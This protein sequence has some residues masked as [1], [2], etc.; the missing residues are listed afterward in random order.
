MK[1]LLITIATFLTSSMLGQSVNNMDLKS[2]VHDSNQ[3]RAF[4]ID[5]LVDCSYNRVE[6]AINNHSLSPFNFNKCGNIKNKYSLTGIPVN[7][8]YGFL[9]DGDFAIYFLMDWNKQRLEAIL[10][11]LEDPENATRDEVLNFQFQFLAWKIGNL[12]ILITPDRFGN[13]KSTSNEKCI[14]LIT[15]LN[16]KD[17]INTEKIFK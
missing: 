15:N 2:L 8:V 3:L 12:D 16:Y 7:E 13:F 17:L 14:L 9:D 6:L 4:I 11:A 1:L 5:E 10:S